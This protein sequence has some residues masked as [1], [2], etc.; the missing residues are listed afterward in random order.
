MDGTPGY[1]P[2]DQPERRRSLIEHGPHSDDFAQMNLPSFL[3]TFLFLMRIPLDVVHECVRL[4]LEQR[5]SPDTLE[6]S[7][8]SIRQ[9]RSRRKPMQTL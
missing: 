8:L 7:V 1:V 3:G 4:R 5:P 2:S 9:V 6:P